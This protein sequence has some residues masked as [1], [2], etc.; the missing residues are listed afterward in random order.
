MLNEIESEESTILCLQ[1]CDLFVGNKLI[2][3]TQSPE[4]GMSFSSW[5]LFRWELSSRLHIS[6]Y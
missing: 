1:T 5:S 6:I 4:I 3:V 2:I